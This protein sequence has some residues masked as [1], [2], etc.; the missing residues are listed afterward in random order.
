M[1]DFERLQRRLGPNRNDSLPRRRRRAMASSVSASFLR[2][3]CFS[4]LVPKVEKLRA[5]N[6]LL[7]IGPIKYW[8]LVI[9]KIQNINVGYSNEHS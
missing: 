7:K 5:Y 4:P 6:A 3:S 9:I 2:L 1:V 8:I